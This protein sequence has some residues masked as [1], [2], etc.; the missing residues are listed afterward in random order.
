MKQPPRLRATIVVAA[1][2]AV[3]AGAGML[4]GGSAGWWRISAGRVVAAMAAAAMV[5][6]LVALFAPVVELLEKWKEEQPVV[7]WA[8]LVVAM[9]LSGLVIDLAYTWWA[10]KG[11]P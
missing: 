1:S 3:L 11:I 10:E 4:G 9:I 8:V 7:Y 5:V 2:L 6:L